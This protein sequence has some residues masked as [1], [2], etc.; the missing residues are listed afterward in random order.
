[1]K[2]HPPKGNTWLISVL[3]GGIGV[4]LHEGIL[5]ISGLSQYSFWIVTVGLGLLLLATLFKSL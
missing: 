2:F 5:H 3:M 4:L 1:M